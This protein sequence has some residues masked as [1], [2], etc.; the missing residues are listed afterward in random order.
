MCGDVIGI[1]YQL[2][3]LVAG[4][5][6]CIAGF[7]GCIGM[8]VPEIGMCGVISVCAYGLDLF[9]FVF[10]LGAFANLLGILS[11]VLSVPPSILELCCSVTEVGP[12]IYDLLRNIVGIPFKC[13]QNC[14]GMEWIPLTIGVFIDTC[15]GIFDPIAA[16]AGAI[17]GCVQRPWLVPI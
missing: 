4:C 13:G 7:F 12:G 14:L 9:G 11:T 17:T 5:I 15:Q 16:C 2:V 3:Q 8:I 1:P 10:C 6:N